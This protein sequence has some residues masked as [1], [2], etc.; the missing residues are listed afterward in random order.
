MIALRR[1]IALFC[2]PT[3]RSHCC[4][5]PRRSRCC[6]RTG[7]GA[8]TPRLERFPRVGINSR[9]CGSIDRASRREMLRTA[10]R[11]FR[12]V[13]EPAP[14]D[15]GLVPS[16]T[17]AIDLAPIPAALGISVMCPCRLGG[18]PRRLQVRGARKAAAHSDDRESASAPAA[19][20]DCPRVRRLRRPNLDVEAGKNLCGCGA[21]GCS[22]GFFEGLVRKDSAHRWRA[23]APLFF[24]GVL[25]LE[26]RWMLAEQIRGKA[27]ERGNSK[28][29]AGLIS[30]RISPV[31]HFAERPVQVDGIESSSAELISPD[32]RPPPPLQLRET[33]SIS[34][35]CTVS[36]SSLRDVASATDPRSRRA[37]HPRE[38][39]MSCGVPGERRRPLRFLGSPRVIQG[40]DAASSTRR[41]SPARA[42]HP[43]SRLPCSFHFSTVAN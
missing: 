38:E 33:S 1:S 7:F 30:S 37:F 17:I 24:R 3:S 9:C 5:C 15:Q 18:C 31:D 8:N 22:R 11:L 25:R 42:W 10:G 43:S 40:L 16:S 26:L 21:R 41:R 4:S 14:L 12:R 36:S 34:A 27:S 20:G 35:F 29:M 2:T 19:G 23:A 32:R 13:D 39:S 6:F 28:K